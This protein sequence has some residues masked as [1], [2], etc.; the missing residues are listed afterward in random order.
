MIRVFPPSLP[1]HD[2]IL[3]V[4]PENVAEFKKLIQR[5]ANL[6]P[7]T[8]PQ[9]KAFADQITN[10]KILQDYYAQANLIPPST[11]APE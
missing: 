3:T 2:L 11:P 8:S 4:G 9:I 10:G 7:D 6:W 5:G 1:S